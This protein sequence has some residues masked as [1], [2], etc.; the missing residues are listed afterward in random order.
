MNFSNLISK[1]VVTLSVVASPIAFA[2]EVSAGPGLYHYYDHLNLDTT[3]C[4]SSGYRALEN[5][6]LQIP[7]NATVTGDASFA[8]G[9][10]ASVTVIIDCSEASQTGRITVMAS[11]NDPTIADSYAQDILRDISR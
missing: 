7:S 8:I 11:S 9:E 6:S 10:N 2:S 4:V 1:S 5:R 3:G